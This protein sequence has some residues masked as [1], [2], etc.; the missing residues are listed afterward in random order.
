M[1]GDPLSPVEQ[2]RLSSARVPVMPPA[3]HEDRIVSALQERGLLRPRRPV[4]V[5]A[6]VAAAA[7]V[8][9]VAWALT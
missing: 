1:N 4:G 6:L 2:A 7:I 9:A 8:V 3:G 5:L